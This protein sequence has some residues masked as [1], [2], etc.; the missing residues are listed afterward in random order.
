MKMWACE[1]RFRAERALGAMLKEAKK[2]KCGR[3][4][5]N[6]L[7]SGKGLL[8]K[9]LKDLG[10]LREAVDAMSEAGGDSGAGVRVA[11]EDDHARS[12]PGLDRE[13]DQAD[14]VS[15]VRPFS[16]LPSLDSSV[17]ISRCDHESESDG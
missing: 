12:A 7:P 6:P 9:T 8:P 2:N 1:I 17:I 3:P 14:S 5:K 15:V 11:S 13:D 10:A 4:L 16:S